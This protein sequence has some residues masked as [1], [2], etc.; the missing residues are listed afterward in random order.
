M[1]SN[2]SK[3]SCKRGFTLIELLVVVLIIG[4]LAAVALPQYKLAVVKSRLATILPVLKSMAEAEHLYYLANGNYTTLD[5]E[6]DIQMP[7]ECLS[8]NNENVW[9]C[10]EDFLI[11][12][13]QA[14]PTVIANYCPGNNS[15]WSSCVEHRDFQIGFPFKNPTNRYCNVYHNSSLGA[16]ICAT[17]Q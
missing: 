1:K 16:K 8:L 12:F 17:F 4:I 5:S 15:S 6:L 11:D 13:S 3:I 7:A 2:Q 9:K 14:F 10:G